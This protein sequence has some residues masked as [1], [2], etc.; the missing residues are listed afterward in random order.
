[1]IGVLVIGMIFF[2]GVG[3]GSTAKGKPT[4]PTNIDKKIEQSI[5]QKLEQNLKRSMSR[6]I[7]KDLKT[8]LKRRLNRTWYLL[9]SLKLECRSIFI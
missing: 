1:M 4:K 9:M 2:A 6:N 7:K 5:E 8:N 3:L